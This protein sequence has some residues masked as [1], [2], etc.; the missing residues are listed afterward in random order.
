MNKKAIILDLDET[1]RALD[2]MQGSESDVIGVR[3]RPN[4]NKLLERL[5]KAKEEGTDIIIWTTAPTSSV[6]NHFINYIPAQYRNVFDRIIA[7]DNDIELEENSKEAEVYRLRKQTHNKPVTA[8][9]EYN[10]ILFFDNNTTE[11]GYLERMFDGSEGTPDMQ[12]FFCCYPYNPKEISQMYA[13][14][15]LSEEDSEIKKITN[16]LL[17]KMLE[18]PG[19][20]LMVQK[21]EEFQ[22]AEYESGLTCDYNNRNINRYEFDIEC[23]DDEINLAFEQ[24]GDN[25]SG[26]ELER[27]FYEY[28][29]EFYR[30][31]DNDKNNKNYEER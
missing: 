16:E 23:I 2:L 30:N 25:L 21:I 1:V 9:K 11:R 28:S 13:L 10:Q 31:I 6:Q 27:K 24:G 7:R 18:D 19:C 4:I 15:R 5:V 17:A 3:L 14:K 12:V 29:D 22:N 8:L 20:D 26:E